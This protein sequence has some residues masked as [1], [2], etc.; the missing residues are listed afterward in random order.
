[1]NNEQQAKID[2]LYDTIKD[3]VCPMAVVDYLGTQRQE[4]GSHDLK[5]V[6]VTEDDSQRFGVIDLRNVYIYNLTVVRSN[7]SALAK[8]YVA[9]IGYNP[10]EDDPTITAEE[11]E[12][13]LKEYDEEVIN[14]IRDYKRDFQD[15][16]IAKA[17]L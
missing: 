7:K 1:M 5:F 16:K 2:L 8:Q 4:F 15:E 11:V 3:Y 13:T 9:K 12:Q 10:F 14:E 6:N 17:T